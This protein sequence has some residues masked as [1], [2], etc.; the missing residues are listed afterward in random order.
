[1]IMNRRVR[2]ESTRLCKSIAVLLI[3]AAIFLSSALPCAAQQPTPTP[4]PA[5]GS[6]NAT[7]TIDGRYL[8]QAPEPFKGEINLNA[9][10][11]KAAWSP[12]VVP[13]KGAP[14]ILVILT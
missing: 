10:Q 8:P 4:T 2:S 12:R 9:L 5:P 3:Q 1:M 14:N 7:T 11:S 13:P 6:P